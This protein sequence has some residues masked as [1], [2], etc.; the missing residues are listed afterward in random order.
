MCG[1]VNTY[2]VS[3]EMI[4]AFLLAKA[5]PRYHA[6]AS[7]LQETQ[8]EEHVRGQAQFLGISRVVRSQHPGQH[9]AQ[10]PP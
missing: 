1:G 9:P 4:S 6:D 2:Q 5:T 10:P 7:L 8:A 3:P